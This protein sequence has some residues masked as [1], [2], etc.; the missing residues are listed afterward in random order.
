MSTEFV[1][2]LDGDSSLVITDP[3]GAT[4]EDAPEDVFHLLDLENDVVRRTVVGGVDRCVRPLTDYMDYERAT[5]VWTDVPRAF[6]DVNRLPSQVDKRAVEGEN[7]DVSE[8]HGM[9]WTASM[10]DDPAKIV[11][12]LRRPYTPGEHAERKRDYFDPF[13]DKVKAGMDRAIDEHG[14]A[15]RLDCH[16]MPANLFG[17]IRE[18][19]YEGAYLIYSGR[20]ARYGELDLEKGVYPDIVV[21]GSC[22]DFCSPK[23]LDT[24]INTFKDSGLKVGTASIRP[25]TTKSSNELYAS[26]D[27]GASGR[28]SLGFE[29]VGWY[30]HGRANGETDYRCDPNQ[31]E[32]IRAGI[33]NVFE[34]LEGIR[35]D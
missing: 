21:L 18:G 12:L 10:T 3:H 11:P 30:E 1:K 14:I 17:H 20:P 15:V 13:V 19:T 27:K 2:S 9:I 34:A 28:H 24:M 6:F 8:P 16:S 22:L 33:W 5:R 26:P 31:Q 35:P 7:A 32:K 4:L 25:S 29:I 23:V